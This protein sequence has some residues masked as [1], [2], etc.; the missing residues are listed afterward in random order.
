[1]SNYAVIEN[2]VIINVYVADEPQ[3]SGDIA[4]TYAGIGW[5]YAND[6]FTAPAVVPL[7]LS[8]TQTAQNA[9]A[10]GL[11]VT[12]TSTPVLN[13]TYALNP[14]SLADLNGLVTGVMIAGTFPNDAATYDYHDASLV[15]HT[16]PSLTEFKAFATAV[17]NFVSS[18]TQYAK[19]GGALGSIPS[20]QVTII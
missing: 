19:S 20:N 18:V 11:T 2:G 5:T 10:A 3:N 15:A 9:I 7:V 16:F 1:M 12:S 14:T 6:T 17:L 13:G 4:V 8:P